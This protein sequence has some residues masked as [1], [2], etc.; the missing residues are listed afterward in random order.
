MFLDV[1]RTA[2]FI[3]QN[4]LS[5]ILSRNNYAT[6]VFYISSLKA[7]C[8]PILIDSNIKTSRLKDIISKFEP[9]YI[10]FTQKVD[11]SLLNSYKKINLERIEHLYELN[12][13]ISYDMDESLYILLSTSGSTGSAKL[14]LLT[15]D[16]ILSNTEAIIEYLSLSKSDSTC[17]NLPINY[18][19]GL[20]VINSH[21]QS[22][23]KLLLSSKSI[24]EKPLIELVKKNKISNFN[25]VPSTYELLFNFKLEN[26]YLKNV[27]FVSQAGGSLNMHTFK[28][29]YRF[30][31][32][33]YKDFFVMYGQT[34]ASPRMSYYLVRDGNYKSGIIGKPIKNGRFVLKDFAGNT[35]KK[36]NEVGKLFYFGPNV[37]SGYI[38]NKNQL[39]N[40]KK[41]K[42]L[43]TGD[44][45]KFD[46]D[47]NFYITGRESRFIK[48]EDK[49]INLEELEKIISYKGYDVVCTF[50]N[51]KIIIWYTFNSLDIAM[52]NNHIR[53]HTSITK[54]NYILK[55]IKNFPKNSSGKVL[56]KEL[57]L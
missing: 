14:A 39:K 2:T 47:G 49:R 42:Y 54:K 52:I 33:T 20:S 5:L 32:K 50:E 24:I 10:F 38:D 43:N 11:A 25:G 4:S 44:L 1:C 57:K 7:K 31:N 12:N 21:L 37:F 8:K 6:L 27:R 51:E 55:Y 19:Y 53:A 56:F 40:S 26:T 45:A 28:N 29:I 34:E 17:T 48:I 35:I 46:R 36:T 9:E 41:M 22:N 16:N 23:A 13:S 3:K 30:T 18:A 15:K